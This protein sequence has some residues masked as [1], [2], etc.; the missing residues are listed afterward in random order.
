MHEPFVRLMPMNIATSSNALRAKLSALTWTNC[1]SPGSRLS[2]EY[3]EM[4][5]QLGEILSL[6]G[7]IAHGVR[8][9]PA[10][11]ALEAAWHAKTALGNVELKA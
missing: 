6:E 1:L 9:R 5:R 3:E 2:T 4:L 8:N 7:Q 11:V 10:I